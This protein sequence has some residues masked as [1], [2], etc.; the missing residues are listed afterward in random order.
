MTLSTLSAV[1]NVVRCTL[2]RHSCSVG[3]SWVIPLLLD[4]DGM[5]TLTAEGI[6]LFMVLSLSALGHGLVLDVAVRDPLPFGLQCRVCRLR[7]HGGLSGAA[8]HHVDQSWLSVSDHVSWRKAL[9]LHP[10]GAPRVLFLLHI[11]IVNGRPPRGVAFFLFR[12]GLSMVGG[13]RS[14]FR[15]F[16][17]NSNWSRGGRRWRRH[18]PVCQL[19]VGLDLLQ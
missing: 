16:T 18:V 7:G 13:L 3:M 2:T 5:A 8:R 11:F 14:E 6:T 1:M 4:G 12:F 19:L 17:L 10:R 9:F 15:R